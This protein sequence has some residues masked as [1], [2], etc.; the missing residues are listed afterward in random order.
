MN[1]TAEKRIAGETAANLVEDGMVV[2]L[3][4]GSTVYYAIKKIGEMISEGL[5]IIG[6]PTSKAT[7]ELA[8][9]L[10]IPLSDLAEHPVVDIA[11]DGADEVS[12]DL[13]LVKGGGGALVREKIV[14]SASRRFVVAI[15]HTKLVEKLT[16]THPLPVE[17]VPFGWVLARNALQ[18]MS[19]DVTLRRDDEGIFISDNGNYMLDC[20]FGGIDDPA[21]VERSINMLPGVVDCGLF[22]DMASMVIV[23]E[24]DGVRRIFPDD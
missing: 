13:D 20:D 16:S 11:I 12:P 1:L 6:I 23:G 7:E 24:G 18:D 4:T 9:S 19:S 2:G 5:E 17:V 3:G 10:A 14:A 15:D 8:M 21:S 22:T